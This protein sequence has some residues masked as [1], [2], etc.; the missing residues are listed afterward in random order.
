MKTK[1]NLIVWGVVVLFTFAVAGSAYANDSDTELLPAFPKTSEP[2]SSTA[3]LPASPTTA[4]GRESL[5]SSW[6]EA[7]AT[8]EAEATE[9][10]PQEEWFDYVGSGWCNVCGCWMRHGMDPNGTPQSENGHP[11]V[12]VGGEN[13]IACWTHYYNSCMSSPN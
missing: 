8:E 7:R 6:L 11:N 10:G 5:V 12:C 13:G 1:F 3:P 2:L 4:G 9:I